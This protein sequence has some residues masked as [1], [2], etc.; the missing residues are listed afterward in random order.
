MTKMTLVSIGG[1]MIIAAST[2]FGSQ[3]AFAASA[4]QPTMTSTM[5]TK[6]IMHRHV[7]QNRHIDRNIRTGSIRSAPVVGVPDRPVIS[8]PG[9]AVPR[10]GD[11]YTGPDRMHGFNWPAWPVEPENNSIY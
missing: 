2:L 5:H 1:A 3:A 8:V 7:A 9:Q 6:R 4:E 11:Y 10:R